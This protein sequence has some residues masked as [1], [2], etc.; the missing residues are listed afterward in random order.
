[1]TPKQF[2]KYLERDAYRCWHCGANDDTL[3]P[4]HRIGRGMGG[5]RSNSAKPSNILVFCSVANGLI[6]SSAVLAAQAREYGWKL[7]SWQVPSDTPVYDV[8]TGRWYLLDDQNAR[9]FANL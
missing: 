3:V 5:G 4:Q 7:N 6:E 2:Q 8:Y 9:R 1:M